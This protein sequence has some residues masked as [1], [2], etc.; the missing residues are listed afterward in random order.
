MQTEFFKKFIE[1]S[2]KTRSFQRH[3]DTEQYGAAR[4][5]RLHA[6]LAHNTKAWCAG[7]EG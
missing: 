2:L 6:H 5:T 7:D 3:A 4:Q 1:K